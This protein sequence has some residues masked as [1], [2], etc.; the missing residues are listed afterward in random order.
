VLNCVVNL[1][2]QGSTQTKRICN[3]I[4]LHSA[5]T[6]AASQLL[7]HAGCGRR[8]REQVMTNK[9][10]VN[11][12]KARNAERLNRPISNPKEATVGL[13]FSAPLSN[14][15]C[16]ANARKNHNNYLVQGKDIPPP[17]KT[18]KIS[19]QSMDFVVSWICDNSQY[20]P[21]RTRNVRVHGELL[22]ELPLYLRHSNVD[23]L[24]R[25]H[26]QTSKEKGVK[27]VSDR[28]FKT[29]CST[30]TRTG[31]YNQGLSYSYVEHIELVELIGKLQTRLEDILTEIA[32]T[33]NGE[34]DRE[35]VKEIKDLI[36]KSRTMTKLCSLYLRHELYSKLVEESDNKYTCA[37]YA[38]GGDCTVVPKIIENDK[39]ALVL[40]NHLLLQSCVEKVKE[41]R[42][43]L[44]RPSDT[45]PPSDADAA[46]LPPSDTAPT[47][48]DTDTAPAALPPSD[49]APTDT[50]TDTDTAPTALPPS[51]AAPTDAD[52]LVPYLARYLVGHSVV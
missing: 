18:T 51:D 6:K 45:V 36:A 30:L 7:L 9:Q 14:S 47:D 3:A 40:T 25:L 32:P 35:Q 39:L 37:K 24:Y 31:T 42:K 38:L 21:G 52:N 43:E 2:I 41:L 46:A 49:T 10:A 16:A 17:I 50:D 8:R 5:P 23:E 33:K 22:R 44:R 11:E 4:L 13:K 12:S 29:C 26:T 19:V 28:S 15:L 27:A 48:T 1:C 20:R 34:E